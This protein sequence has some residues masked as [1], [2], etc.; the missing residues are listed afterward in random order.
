M[1]WV[2]SRSM[3]TLAASRFILPP[4]RSVCPS[5]FSPPPSHLSQVPLFVIHKDGQTVAY[6]TVSLAWLYAQ[7]KRPGF[8]VRGLYGCSNR[9]HLKRKCLLMVLGIQA[10]SFSGLS[11]AL[12]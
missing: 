9:S 12:S 11:I 2:G 3:K 6:G 5:G 4:S 8:S 7:V 10:F 1:G